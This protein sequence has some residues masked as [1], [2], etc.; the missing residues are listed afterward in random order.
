[1]DPLVA[2]GPPGRIMLAAPILGTVCVLRYAVPL[3]AT[4]GKH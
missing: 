2:F 4:S 3:F 1:M